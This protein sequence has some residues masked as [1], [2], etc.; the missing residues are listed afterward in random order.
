MTLRL[1]L[2]L[3][4]GILFLLAATAC[5]QYR[6]SPTQDSPSPQT[7][8]QDNSSAE[9][10][11]Q[12]KSDLN[13]GDPET[14]KLMEEASRYFLASDYKRAIPPYQKALDREKANRTLSQSL[15]RV[16][17]DNLGRSYGI[18][19]DL[20]KAQG[21]FE[22][23]LSKD[24]KYPMFHYNMACTYGE[25]ND[26]DRAIVYLKQACD[27]K[28]NMIKGEKMPDPWGDSSFQRFMSNEKFVAALREITG[29]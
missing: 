27:Y 17:V 8:S 23:G 19:G 16:L 12:E 14:R 21:T 5:G 11:G 3:A 13:A 22:Y 26:P 10:V 28:D 6:S 18:S 1:R 2:P 25:M 20:E 29:K 24:P 9:S 15:W 7:V 4:I